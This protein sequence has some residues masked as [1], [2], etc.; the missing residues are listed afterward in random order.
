MLT[1]L[2]KLNIEQIAELNPDWIVSIL[3][4]PVSGSYRNATPASY[5]SILE[6][7]VDVDNRR[8]QQRLSGDLYTH[9]TFCNI[10]ITFY[11]GSFVVEDVTIAGDTT[12]MVLSGP[13]IYYSDPATNADSIEVRIPRVNYFASPAAACVSWLSNGSLVQSYVCPKISEY[14]RTATLEVDRFQ[15]T[16]FPPTID[17]DIDPSPGGLPDSVDIRDTFL[18]SGIDLSVVHDDTLNDAD[19]D[20]IEDNW[21]EVE[22]H[23]LMEDRFDQFSNSLQWNLYCVIVPKF[24][25]P[26][27]SSGYYGTMFDWGG[28]QIGDSH[29]RQGCAIAETAIRGREVDNLYDTSD[30]KDRLILQ[31]LIH[32]IG[33]AFNLPHTWSRSVNPDSGSESFMNYPWGYT[34]NGGGE[35]NFWANFRWEFDDPELIWMRHAD[36]NDVIFGGRDWIGN[37]LS[38]DLN[39]A[40]DQIHSP[41]N[42]E[43]QGPSVFDLGVPVS[44]GLKLTN[45]ATQPINVIDRLQPEEGLLRVIIKRP[46]GDIVEYI[47]PVRR[48]MA[49]PEPFELAPGASTLTSINLSYGA[50]GHQFAEPGEYLIQVYFPCFPVGFIATASRRIRIAHPASR[51]SEALIHLMTGPEASKF[52]YYGG[53]RRHP[54]II[55]KLN[56]AT[57]QYAQTDPVAVRHIAAALGRNAVRNHKRIAVKKG[58]RVIVADRADHGSAV[59]HFTKAFAQLPKEYGNQSAFDPVTESRLIRRLA[60]SHLAIDNKDEA[61]ST[62]ANAVKQMKKRK[63]DESIIDD[64]EERIKVIKR[65]K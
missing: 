41:V 34:D 50:K 65:R 59:D 12:A 62:L 27:Y 57:E 29:L 24:G 5:G 4:K 2:T 1:D 61:I 16:V 23:D 38:A 11:T 36:R 8:P 21:S 7:R 49:P 46:N 58:K 20:D 3:K 53:S 48:L 18:R 63:S 64:L 19:S 54:E 44:L 6:L 56:E 22:L 13:V 47:P 42:L 35:T 28:W 40:F 10:P 30:K 17:P 55:D 33:H 9:F 14:F 43:L 32:E 26:T 15:G 45:D 51:S 37:N 52:L 60:D 39:P 25:D 31:T